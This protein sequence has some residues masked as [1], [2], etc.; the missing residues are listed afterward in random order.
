MD[1]LTLPLELLETII[2]HTL[3]EGFES[4]AVSCRK[5]YTICIPF[6]PRHN[7]LTSRFRHFRYYED[8]GHPSPTILTAGDL[9]RRIAIEPIVARYI[10][11][12][13]FVLDS[14]RSYIIPPGFIGDGDCRESVIRLFANCPYLKQ[15]DLDWKEY[16]DRIEEDLDGDENPRYSQYAAAFLLTLLPN[17]KKLIL[18]RYW[19]PV[20]ATERLI[21]AIVHRTKQSNSSGNWPSLAQVAEFEPHVSLGPRDRFDLRLASSFLALPVIR[22][23]RCPSCVVMG[24]DYNSIKHYSFG[25]TLE[26]VYFRVC[27]LDDVGIA[28]F[29]ENTKRLKT[30][31]YSHATKH[32]SS[33]QCW[34]ISKFIAAIERQVGSH[35]VELSIS[36]EE[37]FGSII[38]GKVSM[39]GFPCLRQLELPLEVVMCHLA[40][41][42]SQVSTQSVSLVGSTSEHGPD[43][44]ALSI[45]D[46][47]PASVSVLSLISRGTDHHDKALHVMFKDF[48]ARKETSLPA[49]KE[50]H[51]VCPNGA[52]DAYKDQCTRLLAETQKVGVGLHIRLSPTSGGLTWGKE[53]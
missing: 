40:A 14:P 1:L 43:C 52:D 32:N 4:V 19:K 38:P 39:R 16:L 33:I 5:I 45:G 48:A 10:Q 31:K 20:D 50:I 18:P 24:D 44:D 46:L 30:L 13:N 12:A 35:L 22:S 28:D 27:C 9:I 15:A 25:E 6:T 21:D 47:V 17:V 29:L 23:F 41:A 2:I 3:P 49:L 42:A 36:I 34:D 11:S 8:P 37:P 53:V 26:S 7:A 51:L